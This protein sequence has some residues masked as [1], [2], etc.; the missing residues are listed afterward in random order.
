MIK[1]PMSILEK[2]NLL[3]ELG[4]DGVEM[5]SPSDLDEKEV[6]DARATSGLLFTALLILCTGK[7]PFLIQ[8]LQCATKDALAL[9]THCDR[10]RPTEP[11]R[12]C[13]CRLW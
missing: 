3:K 13:W 8:I 6:I 7:T 2:F 11:L 10:Q 9:N 4:F 12:Y 5:D 1:E